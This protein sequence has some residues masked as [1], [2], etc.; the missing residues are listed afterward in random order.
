LLEALNKRIRAGANRTG[1]QQTDNRRR[2]RATIIKIFC[3]QGSGGFLIDTHGIAP[4]E[5]SGTRHPDD[6]VQVLAEFRRPRF[7]FRHQADAEPA[8]VSAVE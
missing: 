4:T 3:R 2:A 5:T 6:R 1:I 7:W 8:F